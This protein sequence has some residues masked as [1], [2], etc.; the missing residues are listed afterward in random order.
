MPRMQSVLQEFL[1][2]PRLGSV[3][4]SHNHGAA[5]QS[6]DRQYEVTLSGPKFSNL[7]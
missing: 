3:A 7:Q 4:N 5:A 6:L 2:N 1:R